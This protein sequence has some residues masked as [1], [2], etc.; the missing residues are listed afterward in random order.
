M[1]YK[2]VRIPKYMYDSIPIVKA[3]AV[4]NQAKLP[5]EILAP[6][7]CPICGGAME[8]IEA[9]VRVGYRRCTGCGYGQPAIQLK[10]IKADLGPTLAGFGIGTLVG[11]GIASLAYLISQSSSK[12]SSKNS[13]SRIPKAN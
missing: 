10:E 11:L 6:K 7:T 12:K 9:T 13:N 3:R 8:G 1:D 2:V 4:V 5:Q